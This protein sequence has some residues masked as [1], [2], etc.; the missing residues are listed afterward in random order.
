[1]EIIY[2]DSNF[3]V[4]Y[5]P[6]GIGSQPDMTGGEDVMTM[7][8]DCL[9]NLGE[10]SRLWL[11]HRLDRVV[12]GILVFAR[13]KKYAALLSEAVAHNL[14]KKEYLAVVEGEAEGGVLTDFL[15]KDSRTGKSFITDRMRA[16][17]KEA[18]LEYVVPATVKTEKGVLSLVK[19][20]LFTGRFH[21]IRAQFSHRG[22]SIVG[23][24][25]YGS[26]DTAI[27]MPALFAYRLAFTVNGK[28]YEFKKTPDI[29]EYPWNLFGNIGEL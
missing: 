19:I 4:I 6:A 2:K 7:A 10:D 16:G 17:V 25:K 15:F 26:R 27:R 24:K 21:Q 18:S 1:M 12:G 14:A 9:L 8:S 29:G 3:I 5:K 11:I 13:N 22:L 23:D 28:K 20:R